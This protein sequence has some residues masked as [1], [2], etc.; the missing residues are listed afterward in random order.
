MQHEK[1]RIGP[2]QV[3]P[4][5]ARSPTFGIVC[6]NAAYVGLY[7]GGDLLRVDVGQVLPLSRSSVKLYN[8]FSFALEGQFIRGAEVSVNRSVN[9]TLA[10]SLQN[11]RGAMV[12]PPVAGRRRGMG[13][14]AK[15]GS[16]GLEVS[17]TGGVSIEGEIMIIP[18]ANHLISLI[19]PSGT[20][21][22]DIPMMRND[23]SINSEIVT[24][25]GTYTQAE[26][27]AWKEAAAHVGELRR[28][29]AVFGSAIDLT[30]DSETAVFVTMGET[31]NWAVAFTA[32]ERGDLVTGLRGQ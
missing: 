25:A 11:S 10:S 14:I 27:D 20:F 8:P 19:R 1:F 15:R 3:L 18:N 5:E 22:S 23:G 24:V 28:Q 12:I 2:F 30:F 9:L 16:Y 6:L 4:V 17:S 32:Q 21:A 31:S 26:V 13:I 7:D 29:W